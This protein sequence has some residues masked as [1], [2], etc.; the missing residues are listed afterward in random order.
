M[1]PVRLSLFIF[2]AAIFFTSCSEEKK[3]KKILVDLHSQQNENFQ[4]WNN[5]GPLDITEQ[6]SIQLYLDFLIS[7]QDNL[8]TIDTTKLEKPAYAIWRNE[9][10]NIQTQQ[11]FWDNLFSDPSAFDLTNYFKDLLER[12]GESTQKLF[13]ISEALELV[14]QHFEKAKTMLT[15]PNPDKSS[16]AVQQ[17][18]LFLRFLQ[19][20]LPVMVKKN[21]YFRARTTK[22]GLQDPKSENGLQGL[23]RFL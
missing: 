4:K 6:D 8:Q 13:T 22:T 12:P 17:Q 21:I 2:L 7:F 20:E 1:A 23:Y 9:L 19:I 5:P 18:I 14:P 15:A 11:Q 3:L 10:N 16:I